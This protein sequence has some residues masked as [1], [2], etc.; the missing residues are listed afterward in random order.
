MNA[1]A[2]SPN[3]PPGSTAAPSEG[4]GAAGS[5]LDRLARAYGWKGPLARKRDSIGWIRSLP[6]LLLQMTPLAVLWVGWSWTA[7]L[8]AV[9]LYWTRMFGITG[10]Y[11]RYFSHRAFRASRGVQFAMAVWGNTSAQ[12]GPLWWAAHHRMHHRHADEDEDVHSPSRHG[13]LWSHVGWLLS[14]LSRPSRWDLVK[15]LSRYPELRFLDRYYQVVP[16]LL[17]G[18]LYALGELLR[19]RAPGLGTSGPQLLVW[20]FFVSTV[21]LFHA[22]YTVNSL[23]H[24]FGS[25]RY[26]TRDDSRNNPWV[27][28]ITLGEGWHNNHHHFPSAARNGFFWWELDPTYYGLRALAATGLIRDL[29]PVPPAVRE[30][31]PAGDAGPEPA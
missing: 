7:V 8:V 15:D 11:H 22:T 31:R 20:G 16:L 21:V 26:A 6:F 5:G 24:R 25:R 14:D 23:S 9:V 29:K 27:A 17:A 4:A 12:K 2:H 28:L 18:A 3:P 10:F 1:P 13:L 19:D 30:G